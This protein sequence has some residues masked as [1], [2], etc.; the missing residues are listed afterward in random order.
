MADQHPS[1]HRGQGPRGPL[2]GNRR[3][4]GGSAAILPL[5]L[6]PRPVPDALR[7]RL[8]R[9]ADGAPPSV[10]PELSLPQVALPQSLR[11]R[12]VGIPMQPASH[13]AALPWVAQ[14]G[15]C[16][17]V[18]IA[19]TVGAFSAFADSTG[20]R[21]GR[22]RTIARTMS[23]TVDTASHAGASALRRARAVARR[24]RDLLAGALE[25]R[26]QEPDATRSSDPTPAEEAP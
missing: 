22:A 3:L 23:S 26:T 18:S 10:P 21:A 5:H 6:S 2:D 17:A 24:G 15:F 13:G 19:A 14:A 1:S 12:L 9:V 16:L 8:S 25:H 20:W 7:S 11:R 4:P